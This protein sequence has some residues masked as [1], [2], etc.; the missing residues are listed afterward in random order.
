M[1]AKVDDP[2]AKRIQMTEQMRKSEKKDIISKRRQN[3]AL[4]RIL[5]EGAG[6]S[7][8]EYYFPSQ[9]DEYG[10]EEFPQ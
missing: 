1:T 8:Q 4:N 5:Q 3:L 2:E 9:E 10:Y 6:Y 7:K